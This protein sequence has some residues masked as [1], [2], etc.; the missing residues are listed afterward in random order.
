MLNSGGVSDFALARYTSTGTL[1]TS[2]G[3]GTGK[4]TTDF[5][6]FVSVTIPNT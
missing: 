4:V 6:G 3:S 2:F 1:D 5:S